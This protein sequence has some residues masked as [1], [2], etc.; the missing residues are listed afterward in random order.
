MALSRLL[1]PAL[2]LSACS[3]T[4]AAPIAWEGV[5]V[6]ATDDNGTQTGDP[7]MAIDGDEET[8]WS[9]DGHDLTVRPTNYLM[10]FDQPVEVGSLEILTDDSKNAV[11]LTA[12]EVYADVDGGWA[13]IGSAH[14]NEALRFT[15]DL[16]PVETE[17]MRLRIMDTGR[18]DHAWPR[19]HELWLYPPADGR[20]VLTPRA[21]G[22]ADETKVEQLFVDTVLGRI[23]PIPETD[24][25]PQIGYLGYVRRFL[26]T[27][28]EH[29]TDCYGEV[30]S[31]MWV[32]VLSCRDLSNPGCELPAI[33]GQ[34]QGDRAVT[35][36]NLQHDLML[37]LAC[38]SVSELTGDERY[39]K[40]AQD[41]LEFFLE[42]ATNTPTG[43]WPWGEHVHWD[44][45]DDAVGHYI[46]EHLG[47]APLRFWEWAWEID[48]DA[49]LREA[50]G[51]INH[52]YDLDNFGYSRHADVMQPLPEPRKL[53]GYLDF[54]RHGGFYIQEW[55]FAWSKTGDDKY[56]AWIDRMMDHHEASLNP[57]TGLLPATTTNAPTLATPTSQLSLGITMLES[58]PLLGDTPTAE[59]CER[60]AQSYLQ[61]VA[62]LPHQAAEGRYIGS[63]PI[64]GI[65][66]D[67]KVGWIPTFSA[68]YGQGF[69]CA[70]ALLWTQ[71]Y[72]LT[73]EQQYLDLARDMAQWYAQTNELPQAE[74]IRAQ[75]F[76][77][78]IN[79]MMDMH[80]L[81][82]G[83][84][85]LPAAERFAQTAIEKLYCEAGGSG[86]FR[87]ASGLW[88]YESELWVSNLAY[89][90]VRLHTLT[91]DTNV[92][93]PPNYFMR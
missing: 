63:C 79:L 19:I 93:V 21:T 66:E 14:E 57:E 36:G 77:G 2:M 29:G 25:D 86:M 10:I 9:G 12:L 38:E 76:A 1:M 20:E 92:A 35:G 44:F 7:R 23:K 18:P 62:A 73:G 78:V 50:D 45:Y 11:R 65:E 34:R 48:P 84:Q 16:I 56:L 64:G 22:V 40:A 39:Q 42:N 8:V 90:L 30:H 27:L 28:I 15:V 71:A 4:A 46:H 74:H 55:A 41:Y 59:R 83:D 70:Q 88:Y 72:R 61:S 26:D 6:W 75:V 17:I 53:D 13:P 49:V 47:A 31:P 43:L 3:I 85:W 80:E 69:A 51:L 91:E 5:Q 68:N 89:A 60:L 54:P 67:S 81:D 32:S 52:V 87:G 58:L 33:E 24:F 37:L 82:G